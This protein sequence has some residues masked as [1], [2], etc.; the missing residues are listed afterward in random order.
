M[1]GG[2][3]RET[4]PIVIN[5]G[6][7]FPTAYIC[8]HLEHPAENAETGSDAESARPDKSKQDWESYR[9]KVIRK[10]TVASQRRGINSSQSS[11]SS[12]LIDRYWAD[13][14][15]IRGDLEA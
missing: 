3:L 10:R 11:S 8:I 14:I 9:N 7:L 1:R 4:E 6:Q 15:W 5:H 13:H 12:F 2:I